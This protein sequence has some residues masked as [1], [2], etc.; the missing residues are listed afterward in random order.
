MP[1]HG[2]TSRS[3]PLGRDAELR[4]LRRLLDDAA[5]GHA[6]AV[7]VGGE[8]GQGK[9]LLLEWATASAAELGFTVLGA[10]GVE[11]ESELAFSGLT[12][13]LRPLLA[14][15][16]DLTDLQAQALRGALGL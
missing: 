8:A 7:V 2:G 4:A 13:V 1:D 10:T 6:S 15:I 5:A 14:Q 11:F 16:D 12:A 3:A 9:T